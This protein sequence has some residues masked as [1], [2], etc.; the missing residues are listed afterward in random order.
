MAEIFVSHSKRDED[1]RT[2]FANIFAGE[3]VAGKFVE[4]EEYQ[5]PP[6][7]YIQERVNAAKAVF[8]LLG[9]HVQEL[10]YTRDWLT[11]ETGVA[12]QVGRDIWVFEPFNQWCNIAIP[13]VSHY[14]VY[15]QI[16][17]A[18]TY[19]K[20]II[21]SYDDTG[22]LASLL[23]GATIGGGIGGVLGSIS[24][25]KEDAGAS[26]VLWALFGALIEGARTDPSR[27]R[28]MG[29]PIKC[30]CNSA[31]RVHVLLDNFPCPICRQWIQINWA[32]R[33][34]ET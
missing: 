16:P 13:H 33:P 22:Q 24:G 29:M 4:F 15:E 19:V 7:Q 14:V 9:P 20:L 25:K 28:P 1:I 31:Y 32:L 26:A 6:W 11:W 3:N 2:F 18:I 5:A 17:D 23:R 27:V 10:S 34:R 30:V 12:S 21:K 8:V